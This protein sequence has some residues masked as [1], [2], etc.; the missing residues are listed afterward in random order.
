[1]GR[2]G[3]IARL[4]VTLGAAWLV[5]ERTDW[6]VLAGLLAR[7]ELSPLAVA[8]VVLAGQFAVVGW[9]W[10]MVIQALGGG[11][12]AGA[13]LA[14]ALGRSMLLGQPLPS[15]LGGDMVRV[16]VL[17]GQT[18]LAIAAR[19]VICDR[20]VAVA[21]LIALVAVVLPVF[22]LVAGAGT[23]FMLAGVSLGGLAI[24]FVLL[25][26]S[27]R[28][29]GLSWIGSRPALVIADLRQM[30][31][32]G[33]FTHFILLLSLAT[34]LLGVAL[35]YEL[36]HAVAAPISLVQ[37]LVIVPPTL[38]I[39]AIPISLG[40]WGVREGALAAG[41]AL[42]GASIEAGVATSILFGLTGP[43]IGVIA[44]LAMPMLGRRKVPPK[45]AA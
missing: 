14:I 11:S 33:R 35:I 15:T 43:L 29:L 8:G 39:S 36:A 9:R 28:L 13:Q 10:Q 27:D 41:F 34:H 42:V 38:L 23:V 4:V 31:G 26:H 25:V 2:L 7:A 12:V 18:G 20:I 6:V 17:S 44:E 19:S 3:T 30:F 21:V 40:G 24:F 32:G 45:D 1:M 22:A 5:Y 16:V 37:C